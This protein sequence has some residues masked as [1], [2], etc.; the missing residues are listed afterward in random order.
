MNIYLYGVPNLFK[1][2]DSLYRSAQPS[3]EGMRNLQEFGIKTII[4]LRWLHSDSDETEGT[5]LRV[6]KIHEKAWH[7]EDEDVILFLRLLEMPWGPFLVHCQHGADR[8][9]CMVAMY[10][11]VVQGWKREEAIREMKGG[12]FGYHDIWSNI[13][14]YLKHANIGKIRNELLNKGGSK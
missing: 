3:P 2:S 5:Q 12:G 10:R 4:N 9:G 1:V 8:T 13:P 7:M 14:R 6:V 11:M